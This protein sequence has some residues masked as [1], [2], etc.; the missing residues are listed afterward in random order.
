MSYLEQVRQAEARLQAAREAAQPSEEK[1][2]GGPMT[3]PQAPA[4]AYRAALW[5]WWALPETAPLSASHDALA[6]LRAAEAA[7]PAALARAVLR[8]A[9][10]AWHRGT[11]CC[12]FC[13]NPGPLHTPS[14]AIWE[15]TP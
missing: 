15:N 3:H 7:C 12:P 5:A 6:A 4:T 8:K 1:P 2:A 11:G 9:A 13:G 14:E 10:E